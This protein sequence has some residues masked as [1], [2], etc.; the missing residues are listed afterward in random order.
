MKKSSTALLLPIIAISLAPQ[1]KAIDSATINTNQS[2]LLQMIQAR[3][4]RNLPPV[5]MD[6]FVQQAGA[7]AEHI[8]GDEGV[9]PNLPP[10]DNFT[11]IH[12]IDIGIQGIRDLGLTTGHGSVL[13][14]A[15]GADE[16]IS[17]GEWSQTGA[18]GNINNPV[19]RR[20]INLDF[21]GQ[22]GQASED[23]NIP[24]PPGPGYQA[25]YTHGV[26][27]GYLNPQQAAMWN[28]GDYAGA[29][30]SFANSRPGGPTENDY[31]IVTQEMGGTW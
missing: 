11:K 5:M 10:Y 7:H 12:R 18:K 26:F 31:Y 9:G 4:R 28:S 8:Y 23:P 16:Y 25:V 6:S 22:G 21:N 30:K 3:T 27:D 14:D 19:S 24:P 17:A 1:A 20:A 13:P 2:A 29:W 15:W